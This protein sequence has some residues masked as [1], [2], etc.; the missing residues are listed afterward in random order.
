[1]ATWCPF[2]GSMVQ[3]CVRQLTEKCLLLDMAGNSFTRGLGNTIGALACRA[4]QQVPIATATL[5][6]KQQQPKMLDYGLMLLLSVLFPYTC[7]SASVCCHMLSVPAQGGWS[8]RCCCPV[9]YCP[10]MPCCSDTILVLLCCTAPTGRPISH[11]LTE[12]RPLPVSFNPSMMSQEGSTYH[13]WWTQLY[14]FGIISSCAATQTPHTVTKGPLDLTASGDKWNHAPG[15]SVHSVTWS[16]ANMGTTAAGIYLPLAAVMVK[17]DTMAVVIRGSETFGDWEA[18]E[19]LPG[20]P[21][22]CVVMAVPCILRVLLKHCSSHGMGE[23]PGLP[24]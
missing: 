10:H 1:M 5:D 2:L 3:T 11:T 7:L 20:T 17:G 13:F 6:G 14:N 23:L 8:C 9:L 16:N 21:R 4:A 22:N 18:G 12:A 19:L 24:N 15:W